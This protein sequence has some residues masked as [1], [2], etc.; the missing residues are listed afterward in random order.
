MRGRTFFFVLI[1]WVMFRS[2]DM[3]HVL[4]IYKAM[5][6]PSGF[7][8]DAVT[9]ATVTHERLL[10]LAIALATLAMP[11]D[12]V[13]GKVLDFGRST[14]ARVARLSVA[15]AVAPLA[16]IFVVAGTFSPFLYFQF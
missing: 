11:R 3:P 13:I 9:R 6:I 2:I 7:S 16:A 8:L 4:G 5:F 12:L 1:G 15:F 10:V 14:S